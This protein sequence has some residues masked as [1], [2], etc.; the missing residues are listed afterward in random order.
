VSISRADLDRLVISYQRIQARGFLAKLQPNDKIYGKKIQHRQ[1]AIGH[2]NNSSAAD[3]Y[4]D[5]SEAFVI[6]ILKF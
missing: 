1:G 4:T 2:Y 5:N 3:S 6:F